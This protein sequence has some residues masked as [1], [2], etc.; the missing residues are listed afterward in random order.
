METM[1]IVLENRNI[2]IQHSSTSEILEL[3]WSE[4]KYISIGRLRS[5]GARTNTILVMR[6]SYNEKPHF[7]GIPD[8][9]SSPTL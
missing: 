2:M 6:L 7:K 1:M 5:G 9:K 4:N 3:K 8:K